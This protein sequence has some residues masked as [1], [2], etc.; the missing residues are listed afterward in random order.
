MV[1]LP[2]SVTPVKPEPLPCPGV[3]GVAAHVS[4]GRGG[5]GQGLP[6]PWQ[7]PFCP[8]PPSCPML[9]MAACSHPTHTVAAACLPP[10][11][12]QLLRPPCWNQN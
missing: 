8:A 11:Q 1:R 9:S 5:G 4:D 12:R 7:L 3:M 6:Q 2:V 10:K